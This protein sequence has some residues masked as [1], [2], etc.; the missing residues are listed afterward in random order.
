MAISSIPRATLGRIPIYIQYL[1][2]L[3]DE[4]SSTIS[5]TKIAKA[6]SLGEVQVRKDL[7]LISGC[8]KPRIGYERIGLIKDLERHLGYE[9]LTNAVLVGAGKLG[10]ALLEY[11]GFDEFGIRILAGF[12]C[13]EKALQIGKDK[14]VY[15]INTIENY[16]SDHNVK[17]GIITVGQGS[18]QDVCDT[19]VRCGIKAIW[20]FAPCTLNVPNDVIL[21]QEKLALSLA[22]LKSLIK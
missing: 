17:I 21:K 3:T 13:N 6:L 16:C 20:N 5:A 18:A 12:D 7:A 9:D 4:A 15:S 2:D 11:D 8:G 10:R 1:R 14:S 19:L 22:H